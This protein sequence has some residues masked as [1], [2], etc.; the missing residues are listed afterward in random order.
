[1]HPTAKPR[2]RLTKPVRNE[3]SGLPFF[4]SLFCKKVYS[5]ESIALHFQHFQKAMHNDHFYT[6]IKIICFLKG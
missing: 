4:L 2:R 1:M 5:P 3:V 6:L